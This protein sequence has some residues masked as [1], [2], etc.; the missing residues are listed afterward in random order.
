MCRTHQPCTLRNGLFGLLASPLASELSWG[1]AGARHRVSSDGRGSRCVT[2]KHVSLIFSP[3]RSEAAPEVLYLS[4]H[5]DCAQISRLEVS[6]FQRGN[7]RPAGAQMCDLDSTN[8]MLRGRLDSALTPQA[9]VGDR[10][11]CWWHL[12]WQSQPGSGDGSQGSN[13]LTWQLPDP[14]AAPSVSRFSGC[15]WK[16]ARWRH[17]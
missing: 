14:G 10:A 5:V 1:H 2:P 12:L 4:L 6:P 13:I 16:P 3:P 9:G 11:R 17:L 8:R 7:V 15:S